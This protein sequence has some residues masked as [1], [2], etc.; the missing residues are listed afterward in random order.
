MINYDEE[1]TNNAFVHS[2]RS[3]ETLV[4]TESYSL[5]VHLLSCDSETSTHALMMEFLSLNSRMVKL[6]SHSSYI[7]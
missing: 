2:L 3:G 5:P 7:Y 4:S 6:L 1:F